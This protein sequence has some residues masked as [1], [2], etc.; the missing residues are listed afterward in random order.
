MTSTWI[1]TD[2]HN[3]SYT[4]LNAFGNPDKNDRSLRL[5]VGVHHP[6][7]LENIKVY[8]WVPTKGAV[9]KSACLVFI[10]DMGRANTLF[11][12]GASSPSQ[13]FYHSIYLSIYPSIIL[14]LF[15]LLEPL[16]LILR[17]KNEDVVKL[18]VWSF[19]E[20]FSIISLLCI[21][22]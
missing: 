13:C 12:I 4:R 15:L 21:E 16:P 14:L 9:V 11:W 22:E 3:R 1:C 20:G 7:C 18:W 6:A 8:D 2:A 19:F 17:C 5:E 10:S